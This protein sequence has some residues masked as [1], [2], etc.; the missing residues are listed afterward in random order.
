MAAPSPGPAPRQARGQSLP[1]P[2]SS[3]RLLPQFPPLYAELPRVGVGSSCPLWGGTK[4]GERDPVDPSLRAQAA[5]RWGTS[6][7]APT[8]ALRR[9]QHNHLNLAAAA[10][11]LQAGL[12]PPCLPA[13]RNGLRF[14]SP[15]GSSG[16]LG[17]HPCLGRPHRARPAAIRRGAQPAALLHRGNTTQG[18]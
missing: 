3:A 17:S 12:E 2:Q 11:A 10:E 6:E 4:A 18:L 5:S 16:P 13:S 15:S 1:F 14:P 8:P 9:P 7:L